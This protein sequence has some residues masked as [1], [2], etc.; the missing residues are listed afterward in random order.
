MKAA[1][2]R[3][4]DIIRILRINYPK[5]RTALKYNNP[6]QLL[7]ATM[8]AAQC[9]DQRVNKITLELFK[10]YKTVKDFAKAKQPKLEKEIYST[11][12][13]RNK[14]KNIIAAAKIIVDDFGGEVPPNM[15]DLITLPG[16]A[17]KTAN[18]VLSSSFGKAQ[19]IAVDTHVKRLSERLGLSPENIP[20]KIEID[21]MEI[22]PKKDWLDFNYLLVN[23]G[24]LICQARKPL[25]PKCVINKLCPS[26]RKIFPN[27]K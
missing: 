13:Y 23:H 10:K 8:L 27:L 5:S 17:R 19:G 26:A 22:V 3:I 14:A 4:E 9:T 6:V 24:R 1:R 16:V 12:F 2:N 20:E 15:Q 18:I 21:L 11:G 25:C 7:I